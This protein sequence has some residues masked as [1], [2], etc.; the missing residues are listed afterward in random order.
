MD[1]K[2]KTSKDDFNATIGNTVLSAVA[3]ILFSCKEPI[4]V[5][6][7][8]NLDFIVTEKVSLKNETGDLD[9]FL[10]NK[11]TI[12]EVSTQDYAQWNISDTLK[13][14][15]VGDGFWKDRIVW[16]HSR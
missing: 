4:K 15:I 13:L 7:D 6:P 16:R 10:K 12:I 14:K 5:K 2:N 1:T 3:F 9:Y 8:R 11:D